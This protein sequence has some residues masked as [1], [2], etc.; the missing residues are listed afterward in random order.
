ML[1]QY[2]PHFFWQGDVTCAVSKA[3]ATP[4]DI[5]NAPQAACGHPFME[6]HKQARE[7]D[8]RALTKQDHAPNKKV[9]LSVIRFLV[10]YLQINA[11]F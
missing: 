8:A 5:V 6:L 1:I 11:E 7:A 4:V 10:I 2:E 3:K 9:I